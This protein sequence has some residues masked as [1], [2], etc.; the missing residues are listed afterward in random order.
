[1]RGLIFLLGMGGL[2][3]MALATPMVGVL[4]YYWISF[5]SPQMD[6]W[7][8]AATPPWA[9]MSAVAALI[10][11]F[12]AR[13]PKRWP[14]N[15]MIV[16][17]IL[18]L[19]LT[20]ISTFMALGPSEIVMHYWSQVA[21]TFFFLLV[22]AALLTE[23]HRIHALVWVMVISLGYYGVT[24]GLFSIATGG[25]YRVFGPPDSIIGDNNQLA[26]ALLMILPLMNYL[27]LQSAHSLVRKGLIIA[28]LLTLVAIVTSYSRGALLGLAAVSLFFWWNSRRKLIM[29]LVVVFAVA[30]TISFMPADWVT[31]MYSINHYQKDSSAEERITVWKEALGIALARPLTGGGYKSTTSASVLH[32]FYPHAAIRA[33]HDVWL[34]VLSENGF[35]AFSVW[36]AMLLLGFLNIRRIRRLARGDPTLAW[37]NDF[38]HMAQVTLI[39]FITAGSFLSMGYYDVYF[40][41]LVALAATK[42]LVARAAKTAKMTEVS[43]AARPVLGVA[44]VPAVVRAGARPRWATQAS[45]VAKWRMKRLGQ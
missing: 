20:T 26:V 45:P 34:E 40:A 32:R 25:K 43:T 17:V 14:R 16:P 5:M 23:R 29:G 22:L 2:L 39:A 1:M 33:V 9:L 31:R 30:G 41:V 37:A 8:F 12:V 11:C 13:E 15:G 7:G 21:K 4:A 44:A 28:M 42:E 36:L 3:P 18:F 19:I 6:I 27:R 10:G 35:P 38:A 24:G